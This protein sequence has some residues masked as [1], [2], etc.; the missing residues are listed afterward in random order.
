MAA[1]P[2]RRR[3]RLLFLLLAGCVAH[4]EGVPSERQAFYPS[5]PQ[6]SCPTIE[7]PTI[8]GYVR[9]ARLPEIS[10]ATPSKRH[11]DVLWVVNDSGNTPDLFALGTG[12][13][14]R[15]VLHVDG[16]DNVDWE[17]VSSYEN[18]GHAFLYAFD[19][20]DN[21]HLRGG[22]TIYVVE[23]PATLAPEMHAKAEKFSLRYARGSENVEAAAVEPQSGDVYY[24]TRGDSGPATLFRNQDQIAAF[25]FGDGR[26]RGSDL[27]TDASFFE[28]RFIVRTYEA[29]Y[30]WDRR[31]DESWTAAMAR[32]PCRLQLARDKQGEGIALVKDGFFTAG[33][34]VGEPVRFY[35][36]TE[37]SP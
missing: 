6:D 1:L 35:R 13:D 5:L 37:K 4:G 32:A 12:G 27:T 21:L 31:A 36:W 16:A 28:R 20:G 11:A 14:V 30:V 10:G 34:F 24:W 8:T 25:A 7:S 29:A 26:T 9:D 22:G 3:H 15:G 23:E 19:T 18:D 17:A 33:E 2:N